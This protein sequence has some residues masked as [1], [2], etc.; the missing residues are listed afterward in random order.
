MRGVL[1]TR[2]TGG[3]RTGEW[4]PEADTGEQ[5]N[6]SGHFFVVVVAVVVLVWRLLFGSLK[7]A[8]QDI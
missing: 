6:G 1:D 7:G 8:G 2:E 3:G 5:R 4:L